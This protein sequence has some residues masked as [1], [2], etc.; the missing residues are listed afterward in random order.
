LLIPIDNFFEWKAI[1]GERAKQPFAIGMKDGS[2]FA[3]A[4]IWESWKHPMT[5]EVIR[6]FAIITTQ[7]NELMAEIH[8]RMPV[9]IAPENYDRWLSPTEPH[10]RDLLAPYPSEPLVIWAISTKVNAPRNDT[11]DILERVDPFPIS[12]YRTLWRA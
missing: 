6:T 3:L 12:N 10:P 11:E 9:I 7:A 8:N 5:G 4:G 1:K 2:L